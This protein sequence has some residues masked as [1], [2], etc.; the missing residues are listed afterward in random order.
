MHATDINTDMYDSSHALVSKPLNRPTASTR[1]S[2]RHN[3]CWNLIGNTIYAGC[4]WGMLVAL[5][6]LTSV[7]MVGRFALGLA[8]TAPIILLSQLQL[9][10]IQATDVADEFEF[11][12]YLALRLLTTAMAILAI[13]GFIAIGG[14]SLETALVIMAVGVAKSFES[15]SDVY[16]GLMQRHERMDRIAISRLVK[17]PLSL[18]AFSSIVYFSGDVLWGIIG[19]AGVWALLLISY[20]IKSAQAT[21]KEYKPSWTKIDSQRQQIT[22][23]FYRHKLLQLAWLTL[24][25]GLVMALL[26]LNVNIPRYFIQHYF[27]EAELGVFAALAYL[28]IVGNTIVAAMGQSVVPQ[29]SIYYA[30]GEIKRYQK[31][32]IQ[33]LGIGIFIGVAGV[34]LAVVF[35][36]PLL[37]LLYRPQYA[38]HTSIFNWLMV[39]GGVMSVASFLGYGMM[40]ARYIKAQLPLFISVV[41]TTYLSSLWLIPNYGLHGAV[42]SIIAGTLIQIIGSGIII[43]LALSKAGKEANDE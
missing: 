37:S 40:A 15:V 19:Y 29:L 30:N 33:L 25:L 43:A 36:R 6:K 26:S 35:G 10:G 7:E 32:I 14:Y 18:I 38:N 34:L 27:G 24:P 31:L 17:G 42:Y 11:G 5:A 1:L 12:H 23:V 4:Q 39:A 21:I 2:L 20:D 3:F 16:Y 22:P 9:R 41:L 28:V 13:T 8:I